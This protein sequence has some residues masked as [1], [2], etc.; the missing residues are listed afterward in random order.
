M[1]ESAY[2]ADRTD[3]SRLDSAVER[4]EGGD[5]GD[6]AAGELDPLLAPGGGK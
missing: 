4:C 2:E 1:S 5:S 6:E 3:V